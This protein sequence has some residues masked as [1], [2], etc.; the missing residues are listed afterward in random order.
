MSFP[1]AIFRGFR[2]REDYR[3]VFSPSSRMTIAHDSQP[4]LL[5]FIFHAADRMDRS[6]EGG[7]IPS[8]R[9]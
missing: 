7:F 2:V 6:G 8:V 5:F 1:S 4:L 3:L 9:P